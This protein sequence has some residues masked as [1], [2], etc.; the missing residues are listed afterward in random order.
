MF[1]NVVADVASPV[2]IAMCTV[3]AFVCFFAGWF[4]KGSGSRRRENELK[5]DILEAKG[6]I[7]QLESSVRNREMRIA[8]LQSEVVELSERTEDLHNDL[9]AAST[10]LRRATRE[11]RNVT[12][13]LEIVKGTRASTGNVIMDGFD[14]DE[15]DTTQDSKLAA[16]LKKTQALY[17]KLK[18]G[19]LKRDER[20][21]QLTEQLSEVSDSPEAASPEPKPEVNPAS[22]E[23]SEQITGQQRTI[24]KLRNELDE[25]RDEKV[26]LADMAKRRS[27]NNQALKEASV[28]A[29]DQRLKLENEIETLS[30]TIGD[31]EASI[32]RL[33]GDVEQLKAT[34]ETQQQQLT[35]DVAAHQ[36]VLAQRDD[37]LQTLES[38]LTDHQTQIA[39]LEQDL[40]QPAPT[41]KERMRRCRSTSRQFP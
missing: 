9:D 41:C 39:T 17:E 31:R 24:E 23:L 8:Q 28:E 18:Q 21:E 13:E 35:A 32:K 7:P 4:G 37:Q 16:Q 15:P 12:S 1:E 34:N 25:T 29:G 38:S 20:I 33:L 2:L 6:S 19:L 3:T 22:D 14:D 27:Q 40:E 26:M 30:K 5:R 11:A 36:Q 10:D